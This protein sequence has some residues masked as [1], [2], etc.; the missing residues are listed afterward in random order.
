[1]RHHTWLT[2]SVGGSASHLSHLKVWDAD[3][4][5][6]YDI[7]YMGRRG[8]MGGGVNGRHLLSMAKDMAWIS[9]L[10]SLSQ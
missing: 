9:A 8:E 7:L 3:R 6:F 1:M 2:V 5:E 10:Q 4:S